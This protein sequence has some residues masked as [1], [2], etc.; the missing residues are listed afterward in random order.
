MKFIQILLYA[1]LSGVITILQNF[2]LYVACWAHC[3]HHPELWPISVSPF[4][5]S[6]RDTERKKYQKITFAIFRPFPQNFA[7]HCCFSY[8]PCYIIRSSYFFLIGLLFQYI[9]LLHSRQLVKYFRNIVNWCS[10]AI[11]SDKSWLLSVFLSIF[12]K[13]IVT[14]RLCVIFVRE[15][16]GFAF[17]ASLNGKG[18]GNWHCSR[19]ASWCDH[20][21]THNIF[22]MATAIAADN[23]STPGTRASAAML[24][25]LF[26]IILEFP[27]SRK[28][29]KNGYD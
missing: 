22:S 8:I 5:I 27:A 16:S 29:T 13:L 10:V 12:L 11:S 3:M 15:D 18:H 19:K 9:Y 26:Y 1:P 2:G 23:L 6:L 25:T 28:L 4:S 24:L 7:L 20:S 17:T 21:S 14:C